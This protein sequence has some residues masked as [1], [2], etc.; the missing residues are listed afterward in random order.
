MQ[1]CKWNRIV[2]LVGGLLLWLASSG[3]ASS[4]RLTEPEEPDRPSRPVSAPGRIEYDEHETDE[5]SSDLERRLREVIREWEGTPYRYG[6]SDYDGIDCSAFVM[7]VC[8]QVLGVRLPRTTREQVNVGRHVLPH[9]LQTG[10]LVFFHPRSKARHVGIFLSENKFAHAS[11]TQ[12]VT[13][14]DLNDP[15]WRES[16]WTAR[17]IYEGPLVASSPTR[18]AA[19]HAVP[20]TEYEEVI[21]PTE[22]PKPVRV[23]RR[24][25]W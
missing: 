11:T 3:C 22:N 2:V 4:S 16:Y 5:Y 25:G 21:E 7:L 18:Q 12:G 13:I 15:Y 8:N 6:G 24:V 1:S 19:Y 17:R 9:E 20:A 23:S 10:D 14:S